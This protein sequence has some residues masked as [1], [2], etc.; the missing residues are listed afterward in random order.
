MKANK[1]RHILK[2]AKGFLVKNKGILI[3]ILVVGLAFMCI[4]K[5]S[6]SVDIRNMGGTHSWLSGSTMKFVNNWLKEGAINLKFTNYENPS[7]IE[8]ETLEDRE[9]YLSYPS[10][11]TFFVYIAAKMTGRKE[12]TVSFLHK[13]QTIMFGIE[14]ILLAS[15]V[16][17]F[18][19]RTLK[20]KSELEKILISGLTATM[21]VLLPICSYYLFNI[22][23]ADQCVILWILGLILIEYLFRT[24]EKKSIGLKFLRSVILFSGVL[25]DYYFW[26]LAFLLFIAEIFEIWLKNDKG[27][28]KNKILNT[29]FW[30]CTPVILALLTYYIQLNLTNGWLE[31]LTDK[32]DERV[33]GVNQT[34][35]WIHES[36]SARFREAFTLDGDSATRLIMLANTTV[37][38]SVVLL[39]AKKKLRKSIADPGTSIVAASILAIILQIYFF[40]QHSAIHEFSMIKVG[41][42][43]SIL[44][45][46][47]ATII[48]WA[49]GVKGGN[50][51]SIGKIKISNYFLLFLTA[52]LLIFSITGIPVSTE[53]YSQSRMRAVGYSTETFINENTTYND[54]V[55][56]YTQDIPAN[57][58][59]SLAISKKRVYK[60]NNIE[61]I[62][63]KMSGLKKEAR[64]ILFIDKSANLKKSKNIQIQCLEK[65]GDIIQENDL[66]LLVLLSD[67]KVCDDL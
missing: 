67:Y 34:A 44:P 20:V 8:F 1:K 54:V 23:Y 2:A 13:F 30:F 7:S 38:G 41:W 39:I 49:F 3:T 11:E 16:Y 61:D 21:W 51:L 45:I 31:I 14:A 37:G 62:A 47:M 33:V 57:P 59:Q 66:F 48:F 12:I 40:K 25:I 17:Y 36:M 28:R 6:P 10:G 46:L 50:A 58:P 24:N 64:A 42:A 35:A 63:E 15:F 43:V 53:Q 55:F 4:F 32:F 18:L 65:N 19:T 52:Y 29:I 56:S 9:P 22:Y 27:N 5:T 26:F 60:I